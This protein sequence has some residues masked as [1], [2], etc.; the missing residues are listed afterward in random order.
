[1]LTTIAVAEIG[2]FAIKSLYSVVFAHGVEQQFDD[3]EG[4]KTRRLW[5]RT[6][7]MMDIIFCGMCKFGPMDCACQWASDVGIQDYRGGTAGVLDP[8][9][10]E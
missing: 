9:E 8:R 3:M 2:G 10:V 5:H 6:L 7:F 4:G 1:M